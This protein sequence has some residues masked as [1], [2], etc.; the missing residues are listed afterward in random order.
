MPT[1]ESTLESLAIRVAKLEVQNRRFKK[2]W[3]AALFI[4]MAVLTTG[5]AKPDR[6][7][8]VDTIAAAKIS[9]RVIEL[10]EG[11]NT[12]TILLPGSIIVSEKDKAN[13]NTGRRWC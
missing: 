10:R 7:I 12:V 13:V 8:D 1:P 5:Q 11:C 6:T 2:A 3:I 9:T 4:A